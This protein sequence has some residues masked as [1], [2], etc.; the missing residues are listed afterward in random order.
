MRPMR[1]N[2]AGEVLVKDF[3]KLELVGY[4][5]PGDVPTAGWGHTGPDV[6]V[7]RRYTREKAV[8]WWLDDKAKFER[9]VG[10][11]LD[12]PTNEN[13]FAAMFALAYNIGPGWDP[14][15]PKPPDPKEGFWQSTVLKLHNQGDHIGAARAF[16]RWNKGRNAAG[17]KVELRGL[18]R[19]RAA[20]A[21]L[22]MTP[23]AESEADDPQRTDAA[24]VEPSAAPVNSPIP[25]WAKA[26]AA[27]VP[28]TMIVAKEA[29]V[30][31]NGVWSW[32]QES[33]IDP[34]VASAVMAGAVIVIGG[35]TVWAILKRRPATA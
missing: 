2:A 13:Q 24:D 25:T 15:K 6:V 21:V 9:V 11:F 29:V 4:L 14:T 20:E 33:G 30:Q 5:K 23:T 3:E 19:R 12:A 31:V 34:H 22:Y 1:L 32:L 7:G 35:L 27:A 8:T 17:E 26:T 28:P 18:T 10:R 16:A